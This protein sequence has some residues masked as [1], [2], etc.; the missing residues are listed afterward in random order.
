[1]VYSDLIFILI[2]ICII[3]DISGFPGS[4]K[5]MLSK[6]L[7]CKVISLKP[8]DCSFCMMF[9]AGLAYI[10][11]NGFSLFNFMFV[12]LLC[13]LSEPTTEALLTVKDII[14]YILNKISRLL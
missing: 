2:S 12:L 3:V 10:I 5:R 4:V 6:W 11:L 7:H 9:W 1:M 13:L 14:N 8:L